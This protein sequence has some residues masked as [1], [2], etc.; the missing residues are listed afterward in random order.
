MVRVVQNRAS[1]ENVF[2]GLYTKKAHDALVWFF[3]AIETAFPL[4]SKELIGN[5]KGATVLIASD[6]ELYVEHWTSGSNAFHEIKSLFT[7]FRLCFKSRL[8]M[9]GYGPNTENAENAK[10][11]I[12]ELF[13]KEHSSKFLELAGQPFNPFISEKIKILRRSAA[14]DKEIEKAIEEGWRS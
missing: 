7:T 1:V 3:R 9:P 2:L 11:I 4:L 10:T 6:G 13:E 14:L 8:L 5:Y 12:G